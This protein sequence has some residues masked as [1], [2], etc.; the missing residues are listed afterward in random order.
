MTREF[1]VVGPP[2]T[3]K[4]AYIARQ[5]QRAAEKYSRNR[6]LVA[7]LTRSAAATAA[8]RVDLPRANVGTLHALAY[9]AL[10][11]PELAE[12][13]KSDW[14][15]RVRSKA[16]DWMLTGGKAADVD[17]ETPTEPDGTEA[18]RG[19]QILQAVQC[20]RSLETD[21]RFWTNSEAVAFWHEWQAWKA[22]DGVMDFTDLID[23][24]YEQVDSP[25]GT[26]PDALFLDEAQDY[27]RKEMRLARK[28]GERSLT[29]VVCHDTNQ[30]LY[31]WRGADPDAI[32]GVELLDD[33]NITLDQSYRV[34]RAVHASAVKWLQRLTT[35]PAYAPTDREGEVARTRGNWRRPATLV[36]Q[37]RAYADAGKTVMICGACS[38]MLDP[39]KNE[40]RKRGEPFHNPMRRKRG[41][42]NPLHIG[43]GT[44]TAERL[45]A[46]LRANPAYLGDE[47]RMWTG[48]EVRSWLELVNAK[49]RLVSGA[50]QWAANLPADARVDIAELLGWFRDSADWERAVEGD[51]DWLE[52]AAKAAS[53]KALRYPR[54]VIDR[55]GVEGIR[56]E[57]RIILSTIH[58]AKGG[59]ADVVIL[60]PDLSRRGAQQWLK[61]EGRPAIIRQFYVGLTRAR[62]TVLIAQ[63]AGRQ[64]VPIPTA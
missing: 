23:A 38:Y 55:F 27:D 50:K 12:A 53:Q 6:I 60:L 18:T 58:A 1:R 5:V 21:E 29:F 8:G 46:Y 44:S 4:T 13:H 36:D 42:W 16:P 47:A 61:D 7:S 59:E 10:D 32:H 45:I 37:A 48:E 35:P 17:D 49:S 30:A 57:P 39:V 33:Q 56:E 11:K 19:D 14:N 54:A 2:G 34:P 9:R 40:L 62:E 15:D 25:L 63:P 51:P 52:E 31:T 64:F 24:A 3:G 41:D 43:R 22:E 28:W 20:Y 26:D